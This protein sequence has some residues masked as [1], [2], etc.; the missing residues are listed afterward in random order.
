MP[1]TETELR[2]ALE[3]AE[4][5]NAELRKAAEDRKARKAL[6]KAAKAKPTDANPDPDHDGDDDRT[7]AGD[8]DH[9]YQ[10]K[11]AK[12]SKSEDLQ[13]AEERFQKAEERAAEA[14][15]I[16]KEERD[17]RVR[18]EYIQK[19]ETEFSRLGDPKELGPRLHRMSEQLSKEDFD[20]HLDGMRAT[21]AQLEKADRLLMGQIGVDGSPTPG[22]DDVKKAEQRAEEIRK[23][24]PNVDSYE[25]MRR[26]VR[27][28]PDLILANR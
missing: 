15:K 2:A 13:K 11:G 25:A 8:T 1:K 14:E 22:G 9:D 19:A 28:N 10:P 17:L 7:A 26:A 24:D 18:G 3:K 20:A 12:M 21:Q 5:E 27:E 6:K 4:Q 16:A 23:A